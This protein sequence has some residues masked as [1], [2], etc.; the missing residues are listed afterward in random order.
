MA[1]DLSRLLRPRSIAV[2]GGGAWCAQVVK[3]SLLMGFSGDI[4]IVHPRGAVIEGIASVPTVEDLPQVPDAVFVGVNRHVAIDVVGR[5]A[6]MGAGGAV[7]FASGFAE[8]AAEDASGTDLQAQLVAAAGDMPVL[9]P[10][11]YG[12]INA[13][14]GALLWPDQHGC[15]RVDSGVAILTQSSNIAINLTMQQRGL[16]VSYVVACGNMAQTTQAEIAL[17]L[18]DDPR[19]T[20]IGLHIE[21]FGDTAAWHRL[22]VLA[23]ERGV[24]LIALKVGAS[25]QAQRATV[26]HTASLAGGDAGAGALLARLGI[27]RARDLPTFVETLKLLHVAGRLD[28]PTLSSVSCSGGEASLAADTAHG[29]AVSFPALTQGQRSAL[30]QALGSMVALSNPLDYNTYI[31]RDAQAMTR[32][33]APMA[34]DHIGLTLL[35]VDYPHTDAKDWE[36]ATLAALGVRAQTGR[37]VAVVATLPELMPLEVAQRL[38]TGG[39]VPMNGLTEA[40]AAAEIAAHLGAP[41][42]VVPLRS[43]AA[44]DGETLSEAQAKVALAE[45][46]VAVPKSVSA[47]GKSVPD[48]TGL[49]PPFAVKG[50]GLAH[51][52]EAGAVR[53]NVAAEQVGAVLADLPG[54]GAIIEE[55]V[56]DGVAELLVGV[57]RDP[58]HGFVLTLGAGGVF[59][60]ILADTVSLLV[61]SDE[62]AVKQALTK[63]KCAPLL[64]G[65]RAKPAADIDS[66]VAAVMAVQSYVIAQADV[67][68]EVEINPLICTPTRAV[69]ADALIRI[70]KD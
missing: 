23:A 62:G 16:P 18:L 17:G 55:M 8:A 25:E 40:I 67:I 38:I 34:A 4:H 41:V 45:H 5:L 59:T 31:W 26:S 64:S 33:W 2:V 58:A 29:R 20:A 50:L 43:G 27:G 68:S 42:A 21:G 63:L 53:L 37:P 30:Q 13:L 7:C 46:G 15:P 14:D 22:A 54:T 1:R 35:I 12:Y 10:N 9:G 66:I 44:R 39:V 65:Y 19:V 36:C 6:R 3:Q 52:T 24:P 70:A 56:T 61:P 48:L 28:A 69:A 32:A 49:I 57:T 11:C 47:Q 51:K 60:E